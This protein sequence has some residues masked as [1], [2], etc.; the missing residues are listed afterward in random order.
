MAIIYIAAA[1]IGN[2][3]T[4]LLLG[5]YS[6][7]LGLLAAPF[8][9]SLVLGATAVWAARMGRSREAQTVPAGVIWG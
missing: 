1:L 7:W 6:I 2:G 9:A 8:G 3:V 4:L 5:P